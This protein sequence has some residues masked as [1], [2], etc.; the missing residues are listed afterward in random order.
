[1]AH[2]ELTERI[3]ALA[4]RAETAPAEMAA[5]ILEDAWEF[6]APLWNL[7][8]VAL[9]QKAALFAGYMDARAFLDAAMTLVP[10]GWA[11]GYDWNAKHKGAHAWCEFIPEAP[12]RPEEL[13]SRHSRNC[14]TPALALCAAALRARDV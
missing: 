13:L 7:S 2:D 5:A 8:S 9:A 12:F 10:E 6:I 4:N 1:M 11:H 3:E 14:A